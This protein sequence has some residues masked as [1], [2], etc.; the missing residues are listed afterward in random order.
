MALDEHIVEIARLLGGD[1]AQAEVVEE[2]QVRRPALHFRF[3]GGV[4][5]DSGIDD[6]A[7]VLRVLEEDA[8]DRGRI[9]IGVGNDRLEIIDD[10]PARHAAEELTPL[11]GR[12]GRE[13]RV[14]AVP[15]GDEESVD[16]VPAPRRRIGPQSQQAEIDLGHL[17]GWRLD[18]PHRHRR[19]PEPQLALREAM[20]R[21][22]GNPHA[23]SGRAVSRSASD[24]LGLGLPVDPGAAGDRPHGR[25]RPSTGECF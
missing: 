16:P 3:P 11:P 22:V 19:R 15:E 13:K 21:A 14:A 23:L 9:A 10:Q 5:R 24:V 12:R 8:R 18:N 1:L 2:E 6:E 7:A 4:A 17:A 20:Q 25:I